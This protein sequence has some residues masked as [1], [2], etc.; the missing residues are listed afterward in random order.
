MVFVIGNIYENTSI[1]TDFPFGNYHYTDSLG[2]K[3]LYTP[4]I[5]N[6]AYFQ[7]IYICWTL[8]G[9]V[10]D[11]F[12]NRVSGIYILLQPLTAMFIMVMWD[13]VIDP[14]MSTVSHHW[15]WLDGGAYFGVPLSNYLGWFLCV[16]SMYFLFAIY[17]SKKSTIPTPAF[18]Y[19]KEYWV[20]FV[21]LYLTWPLSLLIKGF[22][23][24]SETVTA[25]NGQLWEVK[26][27]SQAAGLAGL[28]TMLFV[29]FIVLLKVYVQNSTAR[30][31]DTN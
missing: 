15:E 6:I 26:D 7:M 20:Q 12:R 30:N 1:A 29:G 23:V 10:L 9:A 22:A 14:Y 16:F 17:I 24:T 13:L 2:P 18:I 19:Q 28:C 21:C 27:I 5:I 8:S 3:F 11:Y 25:F 31:I 4:L